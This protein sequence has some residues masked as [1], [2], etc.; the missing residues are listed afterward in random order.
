MATSPLEKSAD[1]IV[2]YKGNEDPWGNRERGLY[3]RIFKKASELAYE[4]LDKSD[5]INIYDIGC[6]G[7]NILDVWIDNAPENCNIN[8]TGCDISSDAI[9]FLNDR[10]PEGSFDLVDLEEYYANNPLVKLGSADIVSIVDI[11]YYFGTKRDY[12]DTLDEIWN[13]V[14]PGAIVVVADNLIRHFRR[15]YLANKSDAI[16]LESF[17]DYSEKIC[18]EVNESGR[19]W[20]RYLK[21]RIIKKGEGTL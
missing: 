3:K 12:K 7:G 10:Y 17:T 13:T 4:H 21:V 18:E 6:G 15:D 1:C 16:L 5:T 14:R 20:N 8:L 11:I 9:K 19:K 2:R